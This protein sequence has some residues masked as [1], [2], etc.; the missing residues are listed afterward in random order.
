MSIA[1]MIF[2]CIYILIIFGLV[3]RTAAALAGALLM[4]ALGVIEPAQAFNAVDFDTVG[5]LTGMMIIVGITR[6]TGLFEFLAIKAAQGVNGEPIKILASLCLITA[7]FSAFLDNVTTV[8][9]IIPVTFAIAQ[10]LR[11]SPVP[12]L[13]AIIMASNIGGTA[14]LVGDPPN[15]MISGF[16]GLGFMDFV[17][18]LLPAVLVI[19]VVIISIIKLIYKSQITT[20]P[21]LQMRLMSLNAAD[22]LNDRSL[23]RKC[24]AVIFTTVLGFILHQQIR[25]EPALIAMVGACIL[26]LISKSSLIGSLK[27]VEW[28]VMVFFISLF[29]MVGAMEQIGLFEKLARIGLNITGGNILPTALIILWLSAVLSAFVDNIPFVAAMIPLIQDMGR[30]GGIHDLNFLW[31]ALSLGSCLGGNGTAIGASANVVVIGIAEKRGIHISFI[32]FLKVAFPLMI[33]SIVISTGY[34][35]GWYYIVIMR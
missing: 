33:L 5:L 12:F 31:W 7:V 25:L 19:Y 11:I 4:L 28:S 2:I 16:T 23:L 20:F 32:D 10:Q 24:L 30:L 34:L 13:M 35:L 1:I 8:M 21:R 14:T 29:I 18:N 6:R 17:F 26:L 27:Y 22:E 15:I 9:L 3:H